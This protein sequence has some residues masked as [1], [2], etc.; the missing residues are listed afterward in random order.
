MTFTPPFTLYPSGLAPEEIPDRATALLRA[1]YLLRRGVASVLLDA[2]GL[3]VADHRVSSPDCAA[4]DVFGNP[5]KGDARWVPT[6]GTHLC[7][8]HELLSLGT[9]ERQRI[10][11]RENAF[12]VLGETA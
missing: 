7:T 3:E 10:A 5:C 4:N 12:R 6:T 9:D 2:H 11:D 1:A 8:Q